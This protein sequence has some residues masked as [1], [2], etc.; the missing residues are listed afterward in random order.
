MILLI[1][2]LIKMDVC[3]LIYTEY[4]FFV[5]VKRKKASYFLFPFRDEKE[6]ESE[7]AIMAVS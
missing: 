7:A 1:C 3:L 2:L 4:V 5:C 6:K